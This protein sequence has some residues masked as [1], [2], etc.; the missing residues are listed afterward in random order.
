MKEMKK[1]QEKFESDAQKILAYQAETFGD[2]DALKALRH[3]EKWADELDAQDYSSQI[4]GAGAAG[5]MYEG[6]EEESEHTHQ[7]QSEQSREFLNERNLGAP[8]Y[9]PVAQVEEGEG[10]ADQKA[11]GPLKPNDLL[12]KDMN[13]GWTQAYLNCKDLLANKNFVD[14]ERFK[15]SN[16]VLDTRNTKYASLD[17]RKTPLVPHNPVSI[18]QKAPIEKSIWEYIR[19]SLD[20]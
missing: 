8:W 10:F 12:P 7:L 6:M 16:E 20:D 17:I 4:Q 1:R 3:Q 15:F 18:W 19:P 9:H 13:H 5:G 14:T 2:A 11:N